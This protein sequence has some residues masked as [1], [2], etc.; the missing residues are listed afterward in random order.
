MAAD[1]GGDEGPDFAALYEPSFNAGGAVTPRLAWLL[2]EAAWYL[3]DEWR[4]VA[5]ESYARAHLPRVGHRHATRAWTDRFAGCFEQL[6]RRF[7]SGDGDTDA[8]ATCTAEQLALH[9][10]LDAAPRLLDQG[11]VDTDAVADLPNHGDADRDWA[12]LHDA[13]FEDHDVLLLYRADL[14]GIEADP[15]VAESNL[16]PDDWF[17]PFR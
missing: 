9:M 15:R 4:H 13:L 5:D 16:H 12:L 7:A 6:A 2:C 8:L 1:S 17:T 11:L 3:F 14:D 10:I